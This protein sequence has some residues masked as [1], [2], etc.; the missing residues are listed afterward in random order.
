MKDRSN[1]PSHHERTLLPR[2]Y[3][4]L[5]AHW[6]HQV[7]SIQQPIASWANTPTTELH[8][9]HSSMGP[10]WR[11]DPMTALKCIAD[12]LSVE[13][14]VEPRAAVRC[15]SVRAGLGERVGGVSDQWRGQALVATTAVRA[16]WP[17]LRRQDFVDGRIQS[18]Q[19]FRLKKRNTNFVNK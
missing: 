19:P 8:L 5:L 18:H 7:G 10:P 11:I 13:L 2:S 6:V 12:L 9:T 3:V 17:F 15:V 4:S 14:A 16:R 1:N